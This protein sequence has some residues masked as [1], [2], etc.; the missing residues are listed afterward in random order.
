MATKTISVFEH[1]VRTHEYVC[2]DVLY[3]VILPMC[4]KQ[5]CMRCDKWVGSKK[6]FACY[7]PRQTLCFLCRHK[8]K[9]P[10][11]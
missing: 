4:N 6:I 8:A 1:F 10:K 11:P 7:L 9:W 2:D 3:D 5:R